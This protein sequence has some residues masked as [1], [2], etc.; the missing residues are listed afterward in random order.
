[1]Q[2]AIFDLLSTTLIPVLSTDVA[3][4]TTSYIH[5]ILIVVAAVGAFPDQ[6][7]VLIGNDLNLAVKT[8]LLAVITLGIQLSVHDIVVNV[9]QQSQHRRD[10]VLHIRHFHVADST[11]GRQSLE[12][13]LDG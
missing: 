4:G 7:A 12:L 1:M 11:T 8:T 13:R 3:T 2:Y 10:I 5:S 9:A 6:L